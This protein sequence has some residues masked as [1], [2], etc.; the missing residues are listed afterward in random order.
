MGWKL[1]EQI[2]QHGPEQR[3]RAQILSEQIEAAFRR[4]R[5]IRL[6]GRARRRELP[7]GDIDGWRHP[8]AKSSKPDH[9]EIN[10]TQLQSGH[11]LR[12]RSKMIEQ[13]DQ[14]Q[15]SSRLRVKPQ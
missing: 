8:L 14:S 15:L 13:P 4:R 12:M 2:G 1:F 3:Q 11:G 7:F 6:P 5:P 10:K 9:L